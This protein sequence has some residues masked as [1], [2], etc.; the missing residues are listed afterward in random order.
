MELFRLQ[1]L[2]WLRGF[3]NFYKSVAQKMKAKKK[4]V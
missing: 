1:F 2:P 4:I 3:P